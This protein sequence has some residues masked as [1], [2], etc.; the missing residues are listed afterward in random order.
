MTEIWKPIPGWEGLYSASDLG[1]IRR[2]AG[3]VV[4][5][6]RY[7]TTTM[8]T[9]RERIVSQSID[10]S[11]YLAVHLWR[12]NKSHKLRVHQ[13]VL[14]AF[15]EKPELRSTPHARHLDDKKTNNTIANLAWGTSADNAEDAVRNGLN[16]NANKT[17]CTNGHK[18]TPENTMPSGS[19]RACRECQRIRNT[20]K[21]EN[22]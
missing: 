15:V 12:N 5:P 2:E 17:H 13:L 9:T 4:M 7:G 18:F 3:Q 21:K 14:S 10:G 16:A 6:T 8:R 22:A 1:R 19:G 11:G 20:R